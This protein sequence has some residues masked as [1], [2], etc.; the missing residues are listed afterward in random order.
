M[1]VS[2][3][4]EL[5]GPARFLTKKKQVDVEVGEGASFREILAGLSRKA[6]ELLGQ[7]IDPD[8]F[9]LI[10]PNTLYLNGRE[11]VRDYSRKPV[12]GDRILLLFAAAGG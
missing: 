11:A 5:F 3:V 8:S 1:S 2:L 9:E 4:V 10:E 7:V 12:M 6:P